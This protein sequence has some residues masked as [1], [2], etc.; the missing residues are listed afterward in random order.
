M[1]KVWL[2]GNAYM[3]TDEQ[4]DHIHDEQNEA[5]HDEAAAMK[6]CKLDPAK[7]IPGAFSTPKAKARARSKKDD[8]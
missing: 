5:A 4:F 6:H 1:K 7:A 8:Q 2:G 3:I